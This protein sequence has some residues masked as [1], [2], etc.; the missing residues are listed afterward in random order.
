MRKEI[1]KLNLNP[2][3]AVVIGSGILQAL[4]IRESNDIDLVVKKRE[5]ERLKKLNYFKIKFDH[6]R[7]ILA[8]KRFEI[9]INWYVLG[10]NYYFSDFSNDSIIIDDVRYISLD[11]LYK[12]KKSWVKNKTSRPKDIADIKL[13]KNYKLQRQERWA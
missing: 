7:E 10:K 6:N 11:F 5:F 3:N 9:G 8:S 4:G 13:I 2:D 1:E 12:A